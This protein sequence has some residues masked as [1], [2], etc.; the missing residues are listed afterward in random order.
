MRGAGLYRVFIDG[1][2]AQ[3]SGWPY[4]RAK[5][6]TRV[7]SGRSGERASYDV[8]IVGGGAIGD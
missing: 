4:R 2:N 6:I 7:P 8:V 1:L 3:R 5:R